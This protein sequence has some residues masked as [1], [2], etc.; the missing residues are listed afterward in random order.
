LIDK[1]PD[2]RVAGPK[3]ESKTDEEDDKDYEAGKGHSG[4]AGYPEIFAFWCRFVLR[5]PGLGSKGPNAPPDPVDLLAGC[6]DEPLNLGP[7]RSCVSPLETQKK[8]KEEDLE[9]IRQ[10]PRFGASQ[11]VP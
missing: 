10:V 5:Q 11:E 8:T 7:V 2:S 9:N 6:G 4:E 3:E 1:L